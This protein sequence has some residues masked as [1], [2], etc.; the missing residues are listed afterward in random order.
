MLPI[1]ECTGQLPS[2]HHYQHTHQRIVSNVHVEKPCNPGIYFRLPNYC[3]EYHFKSNTLRIKYLYDQKEIKMRA[4]DRKIIGKLSSLDGSMNWTILC[5]VYFII[6][7]FKHLH[8]RPQ[9][10]PF[11]YLA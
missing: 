1:L 8:W 7:I 11:I 3:E 6:V 5:G 4:L 10:F 2:T 9:N